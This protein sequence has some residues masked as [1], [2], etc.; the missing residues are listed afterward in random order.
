MAVAFLTAFL[1]SVLYFFQTC[2]F[3]GVARS[4]F[5]K[6]TTLLGGI[7]AFLTFTAGFL[8]LVFVFIGGRGVLAITE[9]AILTSWSAHHARRV[10]SRLGPAALHRLAETT[11]RASMSTIVMIG[12]GLVMEFTLFTGTGPLDTMFRTRVEPWLAIIAGLATAIL[13]ATLM[14]RIASWLAGRPGSRGA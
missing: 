4:V 2:A 3:V 12:L 13:H 11:F 6:S 14:W 8:G 5:G 10:M 1:L 7:V 9:F